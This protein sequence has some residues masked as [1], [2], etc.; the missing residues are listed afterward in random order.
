MGFPILVRW[1]LYIETGTSLSVAHLNIAYQYVTTIYT[2]SYSELCWFGQITMYQL[3][4]RVVKPN[5]GI[6]FWGPWHIFMGKIIK[7]S[8]FCPRK[9]LVS[10]YHHVPSMLRQYLSK[11]IVGRILMPE[12]KLLPLLFVLHIVLFLQSRLFTSSYTIQCG[13]L[14]WFTASSHGC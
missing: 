7:Y 6:Q 13:G 9:C 12:S 1:H 5:I 11:N 8:N 10:F 3:P 4:N 14:H 2:Q